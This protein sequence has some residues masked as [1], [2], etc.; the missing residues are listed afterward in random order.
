M[1]FKYLLLLRYC[2][3]NSVGIIFLLVA[4]TQGYLNSAIAADVTNV[5]ILIISLFVLGLIL[6]TQKTFWI[7]KEL[8][9]AY[10]NES[11]QDSLTNDFLIKSKNLNASSRSNLAASIR[12]KIATKID[13][14]KFIANT[15]VIL[16]LIGT[17]I[18]FI[19]A[20]SGVNSEVAS[21]PEEIGKMV[22]SL[23]SGMSVA[24]YTTLAGSIFSVWLNVCYQILTNG[25]NKL[26]SKIIE[27]GEQQ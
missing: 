26:L 27:K 20:L 13:L 15:L 22:T 7:S 18:G 9:L 12:I 1:N 6:A 23:I 25:A 5:V 4:Y 16:G 10:L 24:L 8:N 17:V 3:I 14:I 11:K 2:L 21:N 19:I